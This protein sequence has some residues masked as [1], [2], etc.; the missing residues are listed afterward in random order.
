MEADFVAC[1]EGSKQ[2]IWL[3]NFIIQEMVKEE[4]IEVQHL[5]TNLMVADPLTKALPI[6]VFKAYVTRMGVLESFDQLE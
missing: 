1:F 2:A 6:G 3:K 5:N 4:A